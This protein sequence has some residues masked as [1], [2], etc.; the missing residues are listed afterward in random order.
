MNAAIIRLALRSLLG[1]SRVIV[2]MAM[3]AAL[4]LL[5]VIIRVAPTGQLEATGAPLDLVRTFG[6]GVVVPIVTLIGTT[7]L[8]TSEIDDGS[9]IYLLSKPV[10]RGA[11][12]ASKMLVIL[13]SSLAFAVVPMALAALI[14]VGTDGG[15]WWSALLGGSVSAIAYTGAF[16]LLALL[17]K[18]SVTGCLLYWLVWEALLTSVLEPAQY[19]SA[20]AY[21]SS[22]LHAGL[23]VDAHPAA[24][25]SAVAAVV[26]LVAGAGLAGRR[27]ARTTISEV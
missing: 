17:I 15:L 22:V 14:M 8:L 24:G 4:V 19:L 5:A 18:R 10:P 26:V 7:T 13:A 21:G 1:R 2:L 6:I 11:I 12:V 20:R 16:A 27:L 25:F 23:G 3:S 9:I